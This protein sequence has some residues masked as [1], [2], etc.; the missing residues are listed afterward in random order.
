MQR[1]TLLYN[2]LYSYV[3]QTL[4][5]VTLVMGFYVFVMFLKRLQNKIPDFMR[6]IVIFFYHVITVIK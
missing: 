6:A 2:A 3:S 5:F 4:L 1:Y